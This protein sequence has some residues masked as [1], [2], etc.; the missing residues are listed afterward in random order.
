MKNFTTFKALA[1]SLLC[2]LPA[3]LAAKHYDDHEYRD[4]DESCCGTPL[5]CGGFNLEVHGGIAP[6]LWNDRDCFLLANSATATTTCNITQLT[7]LGGFRNFDNLF[8][9]PWDVG[10]RVGYGVTEKVEATFE[11][12]YR[13]ASVKGNCGNNNSCNTN[14]NCC[15]TPSFTTTN[16]PSQ[17]SLCYS[18]SVTTNGNT[19]FLF[20]CVTPYKAYAGHVGARWYTDRYWCDSV[21]FFLGIK[22]GFVVHKSINAT[23]NQVNV[24]AVGTTTIATTPFPFTCT[25]VY[26][27]NTTISAGGLVGFDWCFWNRLSF[28]FQAEFLGQ[29]P[30]R[31]S[32]NIGAVVGSNSCSTCTSC[33]TTTATCAN[34]STAQTATTNLVG[35]NFN[36][37]VVFPVL[38]GLKYYF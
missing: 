5:Y 1:L 18:T 34:L 9:L 20:S 30:L 28:V 17:L 13:Q 36:T 32:H 7:A 29:G 15:Y 11:F 10:F 12:D 16:M 25:P 8:Q 31:A 35:P 24:N 38:F 27:K 26:F 37:E 14:N 22:V 6:I 2:V 21:A 23:I 19:S 33:C 4:A 3:S